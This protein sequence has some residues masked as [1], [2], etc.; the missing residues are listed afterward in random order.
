MLNVKIPV[1]LSQVHEPSC[2]T[3][4]HNDRFPSRS[5]TIIHLTLTFNSDLTRPASPLLCDQNKGM[6]RDGVADKL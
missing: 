4:A 3:W 2:E 6:G 1:P 5:M